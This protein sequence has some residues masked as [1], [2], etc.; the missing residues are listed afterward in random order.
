MHSAL[1]HS[2]TLIR[3]STSSVVHCILWAVHQDLARASKAVRLNIFNPFT[4]F[5]Q[6]CKLIASF[7]VDSMSS[8]VGQRNAR[9][10]I[11]IFGG[12]RSMMSSKQCVGGVIAPVCT[13]FCLPD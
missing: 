4:I 11:W 3:A 9:N 8:L 6:T 1:P 5:F 10:D 12:N 2:P 13:P 7:D